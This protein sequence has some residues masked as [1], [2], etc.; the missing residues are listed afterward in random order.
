[1][2]SVKNPNT[3]GRNRTI[4]KRAAARKSTLQTRKL[5]TLPGP[6]SRVAKA[7]ARRGARGGVHG[8]APTSG[9]N[10]PLSKKKARKVE[11]AMAHAIRRKREEEER[12]ER[13]ERGEYIPLR[14]KKGAGTKGWRV[15]LDVLLTIG[16]DA[17][18]AV[19]NKKQIKQ[20]RNAAIDALGKMDIS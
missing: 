18:D 9:P 8:L 6:D 11:K 17:E 16:I 14:Y 15:D 3:V 12:R 13:E 4:A 20:E 5:A 2:P 7:D 10:A 1:M 19:K